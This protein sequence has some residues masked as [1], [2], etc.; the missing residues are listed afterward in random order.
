M[1]LQRIVRSVG[2]ALL[3]RAER[4]TITA[5]GLV[6]DIARVLLLAFCEPSTR[7][8]FYLSLQLTPLP[9]SR[10]PT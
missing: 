4:G 1:V 7:P 10:M 2:A 8:S 3:S 9:G 6:A 5:E